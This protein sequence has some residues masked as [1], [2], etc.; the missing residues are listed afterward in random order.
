MRADSTSV[1]FDILKAERRR[2]GRSEELLV[3]I[4]TWDDSEEVRA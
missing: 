4:Q 3:E 2:R 1:S